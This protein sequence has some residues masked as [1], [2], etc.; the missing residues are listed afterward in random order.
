MGTAVVSLFAFFLVIGSTMTAI[1][2][3]V[4]TGSDNA[5]SVSINNES[6][7]RELETSVALMSATATTGGGVTQIDVVVTNDGHRAIADFGEW[8]VTVRYDQTGAADETA[9]LAPYAPSTT[10]NS[11]TDLNFWLDHGNSIAELIEPKRL[12]QH[13]EMVMRIQLNPEVQ[14]STS[15]EV[16]ITIPT[17]LTGTIYFGG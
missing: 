11:W 2:T 1:N 12:N 16:S 6:L 17:G 10:D 13:E 8:D 5:R 7:V 15:G 9:L 3:V 4:K 14:A